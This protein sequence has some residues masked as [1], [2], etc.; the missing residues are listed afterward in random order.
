MRV[1]K[2]CMW[3]AVPGLSPD[4]GVSGQGLPEGRASPDSSGPCTIN[5]GK[6]FVFFRETELFQ[7]GENQCAVYLHFK[8]ATAALDELGNQPV[9]IFD[10]VLQTCS[11]W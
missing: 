4:P 8:G 3:R 5:S 9:L 7:L 11:V 6:N 2:H 10:R 1:W